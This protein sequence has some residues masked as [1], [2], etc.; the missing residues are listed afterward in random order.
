MIQIFGIIEGSISCGKL[1]WQRK[2]HIFSRSIRIYQRLF[3]INQ[4]CYCQKGKFQQSKKQNSSLIP[5]FSFETRDLLRV[6]FPPNVPGV[7]PLTLL[8]QQG[9]DGYWIWKSLRSLEKL[10]WLSSAR[11]TTTRDL[12]QKKNGF[13]WRELY[14]WSLEVN[15]YVVFFAGCSVTMLVQIGWIKQLK[16]P[17]KTSF[18]PKTSLT[19]QSWSLQNFFGSSQI[20]H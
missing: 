7:T 19:K 4:P 3:N 11:C 6:F 10:M 18:I 16:D 15:W 14:T 8:F 12:R 2:K 5:F 9:Q 1:T 13:K 20:N 17:Y